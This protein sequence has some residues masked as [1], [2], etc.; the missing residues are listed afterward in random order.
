MI[1]FNVPHFSKVHREQLH[2]MCAAPPDLNDPKDD[3]IYLPVDSIY[4]TGNGLPSFI[5]KHASANNK[6]LTISSDSDVIHTHWNLS[7]LIHDYIS[8]HKQKWLNKLISSRLPTLQHCLVHRSTIYPISGLNGL[9]LTLLSQKNSTTDN[10]WSIDGDFNNPVYLS[11]YIHKL[12][13]KPSLSDTKICAHPFI[14]A[15]ECDV[16]QQHIYAGL[17]V[18]PFNKNYRTFC[19]RLPFKPLGMQYTPSS[20]ASVLIN[21]FSHFGV[22]K[23]ATAIAS[24]HPDLFAA[25]IVNSVGLPANLLLDQTNYCSLIDVSKYE[26]CE[27]LVKISPLID[28]CSTLM[29][30]ESQISSGF[31]YFIDQINSDTIQ[32]IN[33]T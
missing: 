17:K 21:K 26:L 31:S 30:D 10:M 19:E 4:T 6:L 23:S 13:F 2:A 9:Y 20:W 12:D 16:F 22:F 27:K 7:N 15:K 33:N 32:N 25:L 14:H 11:S 28:Y 1:Y 3:F 8:E 29:T 24:E 5:V 18:Y